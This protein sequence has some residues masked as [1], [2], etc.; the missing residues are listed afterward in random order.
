M[1]ADAIIAVIHAGELI[2]GGRRGN[3]ELAAGSA[4]NVTAVR[5]LLGAVTEPLILDW[6]GR[7]VIHIRRA[8]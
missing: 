3:N 8:K 2:G 7:C 5:K 4:R 1:R 6:D